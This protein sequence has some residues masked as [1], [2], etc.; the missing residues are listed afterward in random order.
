MFAALTKRVVFLTRDWEFIRKQ[1]ATISVWWGR[2]R[3]E[4]LA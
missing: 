3:L 1:G 2:V 4:V